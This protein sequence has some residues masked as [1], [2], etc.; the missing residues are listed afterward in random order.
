MARV[1]I[2]EAGPLIAFAGIYRLV[3]VKR[4]FAEVMV[5]QSVIE[6]CLAK[7]GADAQRVKLA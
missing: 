7:E 2:A 3:I 5:L 1:V 4:L 6:E